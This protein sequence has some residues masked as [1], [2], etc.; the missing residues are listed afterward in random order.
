MENQDESSATK[1]TADRSPRSVNKARN[2]VEE[3][4]EEDEPVNQAQQQVEHNK[5]G[6]QE[7]V[8]VDPAVSYPSRCMVVGNW[9]C[10][11]SIASISSC[12]THI[13][14][15]LHTDDTQSEHGVPHLPEIL[16]APAHVH[17]LFSKGLLEK[18]RG[19]KICAQDCSKFT[20]GA[21]TVEGC[22]LLDGSNLK[23]PRF[24]ARNRSMKAP[25][26]SVGFNWEL[27]PLQHGGGGRLH[28]Q[29]GPVQA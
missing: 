28:A 22:K 10:N 12:V 21:H 7:D 15:R 3:E 25:L 20:C 16:L 1:M 11:G 18:D 6:P 9:K 26:S 27:A 8:N 29:G 2:K 23:A 13:N 17:L 24:N 19:A 14:A 4:E 5:A